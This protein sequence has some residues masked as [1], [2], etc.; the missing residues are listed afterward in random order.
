MKHL[1]VAEARVR[2]GEIL[3]EAEKG[4]PVFIERRGVRFRVI[5]EP[6]KRTSASAPRPFEFVASEVMAGQWTWSPG[7]GGLRFAPRDDRPRLARKKKP[8]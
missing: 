4:E 2:F 1:K 7:A 3:D 8:R 6:A 5:A